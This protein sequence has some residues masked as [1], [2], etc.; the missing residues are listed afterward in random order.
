MPKSDII[1]FYV[2]AQ[3]EPRQFSPLHLIFMRISVE[4]WNAFFMTVKLFNGN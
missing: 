2:F 1:Y 3:I 4:A